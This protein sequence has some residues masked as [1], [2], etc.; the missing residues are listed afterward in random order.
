[1]LSHLKFTTLKLF[2]L[3]NHLIYTLLR[4]SI[5]AWKIHVENY[6]NLNIRDEIKLFFLLNSLVSTLKGYFF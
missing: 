4:F 1:M 2:V 3:K 5:W 6:R